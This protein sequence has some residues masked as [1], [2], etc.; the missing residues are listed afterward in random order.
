[1]SQVISHNVPVLAQDWYTQFY[2]VLPVHPQPQSG[3][4]FTGYLTR[5]AHAN[6]ISQVTALANSLDWTLDMVRQPTEC[7]PSSWGQLP[8]AVACSTERL[9]AT[10]LFYLGR[11]FGRSPHGI[12]RFVSDTFA[13]GVCYCPR[14]LAEQAQPHYLLAWRFRALDGCPVHSCRLMDVCGHCGCEVRPLAAPLRVGVCPSCRGDLSRCSS[15]GLTDEELSTAARRAEDL[16]FLLSPE[17]TSYEGKFNP[18]ALG[19]WF[20]TQRRARGVLQEELAGTLGMKEATLGGLER[21]ET[22]LGA[23]LADYVAYVDYLG[24]TLQQAFTASVAITAA[25]DPLSASSSDSVEP[26]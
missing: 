17:P 12:S 22:R 9:L 6:G 23:S 2:D 20:G 14:C 4:S 18:V 10:T 19:A 21:G 7:P 15:E 3:E 8:Q 13:K 11:K 26:P 5:L 25:P 1:M 24:V 16:E